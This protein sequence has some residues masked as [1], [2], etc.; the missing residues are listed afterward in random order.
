MEHRTYA[1][2]HDSDT[3]RELARKVPDETSGTIRSTHDSRGLSWDCPLCRLKR[4]HPNQ[5]NA[6][7]ICGLRLGL[8]PV[9]I[10]P[11]K[12][13]HP[14]SSRTERDRWLFCQPLRA[15]WLR[16]EPRHLLRRM[17]GNRHPECW[18]TRGRCWRPNCIQHFRITH[19]TET[20]RKVFCVWEQKSECALCY[21]IRSSVKSRIHIGCRG[22]TNPRSTRRATR[23][24]R[25]PMQLPKIGTRPKVGSGASPS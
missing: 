1:N 5:G 7:A 13:F 22:L 6:T 10:G 15:R 23:C 8:R 2:R 18:S 12:G 24:R 9:N 11:P 14:L 3:V 16:A 21:P 17:T 19:R 20:L 25:M 4:A